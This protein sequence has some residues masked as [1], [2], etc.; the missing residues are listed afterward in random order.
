MYV[1]SDVQAAS[2]W[3]SGDAV[4]VGDGTKLGRGTGGVKVGVAVPGS[5]SSTNALLAVES[6]TSEPQAT[7]NAKSMPKT[8]NF[9]NSP[10]RNT[11][12]QLQE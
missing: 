11:E 2:N 4:C 12:V 7:A 9:T 1:D 8:A 10:S 5:G 6:V 3:G